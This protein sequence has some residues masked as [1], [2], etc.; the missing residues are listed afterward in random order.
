MKQLVACHRALCNAM[1]KLFFSVNTIAQKGRM[2]S[3]SLKHDNSKRPIE[4]CHTQFAK[5]QVL[6]AL[7][8][9]QMPIKHTQNSLISVF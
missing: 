2:K 3:V 8:E 5:T 6:V 9:K 4:G 7:S 1:R